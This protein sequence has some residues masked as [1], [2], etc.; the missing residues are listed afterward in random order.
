MRQFNAREF[1]HAHESWEAIWLAAPQ[2]EKTFLQGIIQISAA[3][4]HHQRKNLIGARALLRRGLAKVEA[5]PAN[6]RGLRLEALRRAARDWL[7]E[8]ESGGACA[9]KPYPRLKRSAAKPRASRRT[10]ALAVSP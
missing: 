8:L 7:E 10:R 1:W 3:F 4:Y 6:H 2:P 5:F 9:K